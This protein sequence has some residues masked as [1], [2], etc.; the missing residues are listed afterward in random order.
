M[1]LLLVRS[2][3]NLTKNRT[4]SRHKHTHTHLPQSRPRRDFSKSS[5]LIFKATKW[6]R[7]H[8]R[9]SGHFWGLEV[10]PRDSAFVK[11]TIASEQTHVFSVRT[12]RK[13]KFKLGGRVTLTSHTGSSPTLSSSGVDEWGLLEFRAGHGWSART[14]KHTRARNER[15]RFLK[16]L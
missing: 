14:H 16:S 13:C 2:W 9:V 15:W 10:C 8:Q 4:S 11:C 5:C 12:H 6:L 1:P 7:P 3:N